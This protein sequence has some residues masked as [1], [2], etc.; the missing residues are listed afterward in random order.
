MQSTE[1][2]W[3]AVV[4][5]CQAGVTYMHPGFQKQSSCYSSCCGKYRH[6]LLGIF[7]PCASQ[8][9]NMGTG[10]LQS[11]LQPLEET[12]W[13]QGAWNSP[14]QATPVCTTLLA[15]GGV[16]E[17]CAYKWSWAFTTKVAATIHKSEWSRAKLQIIHS[18]PILLPGRMLYFKGINIRNKNAYCLVEDKGGGN[19]I[20]EELC[21]MCQ[22]LSPNSLI[23]IPNIHRTH[24]IM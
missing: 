11:S 14:T 18:T 22:A 16:C 12:R 7:I 17:Q 10:S 6:P 3:A 21:T 13:N 9:P 1:A 23:H 19:N 8:A 5:L 2:A 15:Q 20:I 24:R 4:N